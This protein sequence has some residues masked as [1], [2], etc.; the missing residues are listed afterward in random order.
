MEKVMSRSLSLLVFVFLFSSVSL[1]QN[2]KRQTFLS[3]NFSK[4]ESKVRVAFFD[5]DSTLRVSIS[6]SVSANAVDD[7]MLLPDVEVKIAELVKQ[8]YLVAIVS[9]QG[10][11][12]AGLVTHEVADGALYHTIELIKA[13]NPEAQIQYF[14]YAEGDDEARKP[15][16]G[17]GQR[18]EK[19]LKSIGLQIDW[20]NSF[21]VG[22]SAYKKTDQRPDG[23]PGTHF[24]NSDRLFAENLKI[25]F[26]EPTDFFGWRIYGIDVFEKAADVENF[27]KKNG[28]GSQCLKFLSGK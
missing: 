15:G 2:L 19:K 23:K 26:F 9:N 13:K 24:S 25:P 10:G 11:I 21:M 5:A 27:V 3:D 22:D 1:A 12:K 4:K 20:E 14:D 6:G 17:M 7:V 16:T 8:G 18:L 28:Q